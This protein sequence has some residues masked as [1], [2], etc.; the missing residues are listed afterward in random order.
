MHILLQIAVSFFTMYIQVF[1]L[2]T[3]KNKHK[4]N[5]LFMNEIETKL[6]IYFIKQL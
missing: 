2:G 1:V 5:M 6:I 4:E 3:N